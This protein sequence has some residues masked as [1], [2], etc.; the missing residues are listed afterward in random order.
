MKKRV[1]L[2]IALGAAVV[3]SL[4]A[5]SLGDAGGGGGPGGGTICWDCDYD[6]HC[7]QVEEGRTSCRRETEYYT[8]PDGGTVVLI[9]CEPQ[10]AV[11]PTSGGGGGGGGDGSAPN[12]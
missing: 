8:L 11:C 7:R 4:P 12:E 9:T 10:G 6:A 2:L 5:S 1:V 3:L